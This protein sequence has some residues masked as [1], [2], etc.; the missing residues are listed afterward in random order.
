MPGVSEQIAAL[1]EELQP[2][3]VSSKAVR[4]RT[5]F[6]GSAPSPANLSIPFGAHRTTVRQG[7]QAPAGNTFCPAETDTTLQ[8]SY[9]WFWRAD[10]PSEP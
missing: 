9:H 10:F 1:Q 7:G 3:A 4:R 2:H 8:E 6:A 5:T